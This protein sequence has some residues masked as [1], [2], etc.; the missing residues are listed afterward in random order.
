MQV[1]FDL[2]SLF[3][4]I[5]LTKRQ[6][7]GIFFLAVI[8]AVFEM[9]GFVLLLSFLSENEKSLIPF[10]I[11]GGALLAFLGARLFFGIAVNWMLIRFAENS[12]VLMRQAIIENIFRVASTFE[13]AQVVN[14][15]Q[16][17]APRVSSMII[18]NALRMMVDIFVLFAVA[19]AGLYVV[20]GV[21][22]M[23]IGLLISV[24]LATKLSLRNMLHRRGR[25]AVLADQRLIELAKA[26]PD[27]AMLFE[28][29]NLSRLALDNVKLLARQYASSATIW[30][31]V[32]S[33]PRFVFE[34]GLMLAIAALAIFS[35]GTGI[36]G[37]IGAE[38]LSILL[39]LFRALPSLNGML[40]RFSQMHYS[41]DSIRHMM[42]FFNSSDPN[43]G[44]K[45]FSLER[46]SNGLFISNLNIRVSN[47]QRYLWKDD[48]QFQCGPTGL[49]LIRGASGIGKSALAELIAGES[50]R[51]ARGLISAPPGIYLRQNPPLTPGSFN[52]LLNELDLSDFSGLEA[53]FDG[54]PQDAINRM[55]N[56]D[57]SINS[58]L[59]GGERM[60]LWVWLVVSK[61]FTM[62]ILDEPT[63]P[64]DAIAANQMIRYLKAKSR[65]RLILVISHD[66]AWTKFADFE[67]N[68]R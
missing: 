45:G 13:S 8:N 56:V 46:S 14:L 52:E 26:L 40:S 20:G 10:S 9:L 2:N 67:I 39:L 31:L 27:G 18:L 17:I 65:Q 1:F 11:S 41:S 3:R 49:I 47:Q 7:L 35:D 43:A 53:L 23:A 54:Y 37:V 29:L 6:I 22:L 48:L 57:E 32:S 59:S 44:E 38:F 24:G 50:L 19:L 28:K 64:L 25:V 21:F 33:G 12:T 68:L 62:T 66:L 15:S 58:T 63:A 60:R 34:N 36:D 61:E 5:K 51:N 42:D 30:Q 4:K 16:T 55:L